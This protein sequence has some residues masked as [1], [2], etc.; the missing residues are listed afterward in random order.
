L[1]LS[2][3]ANIALAAF[4]AALLWNRPR[5][6]PARTHAPAPTGHSRPLPRRGGVFAASRLNPATATELERSGISRDT[7]AA[8]LLAELNLRSTQEVL[9]L[10]R[11][12]A[13][14]PVPQ[15][16]MNL[17]A[18]R[19]DAER[20]R[21]LQQFLGPDGYRAWDREQTLRELDLTP[22]AEASLTGDE[23]ENAYRLQKECDEQC[24]DLQ[25]AMEDGVAD[26]AAVGTLQAQA[27]ESLDQGLK[28]LLGKR[29]LATLRSAT[30]A[31]PGPAPADPTF[32]ALTDN[33]GAWRLD[34]QSVRSVYATLHTFQDQAARLR[35]A[36]QQSQ[37]SGQPADWPATESAVAQ[38]R[39]QTEADLR[40][41]VGSD[42]AWRL[43][44]NGLLDP[45]GPHPKN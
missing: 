40:D 36:A 12:F 22:G 17:F 23:A 25:Q 44:Q 9:L 24:R 8:V 30:D 33:A 31:A 39:Q 20:I 6:A 15:D 13:P 4:L 34:D 3:T 38:A 42:L 35:G 27:R 14:Q 11:R 21:A 2:L 19:C 45:T 18:R 43:E 5:P 16:E 10:Q 41:L 32:Q 37:A 29:R 1:R 26:P 7:L 28:A